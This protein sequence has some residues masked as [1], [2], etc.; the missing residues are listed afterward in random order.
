MRA[1]S[2]ITT[3]LGIVVLATMFVS[4]AS[5]ECGPQQGAK[6]QKQS[7]DGVS[8]PAS[9]L[10]VNFP[11]FNEPIVGMWHVVFT[12]EGNKGSM[13]PPDGA[14]IDNAVAVWHNDGTEIMNSGRP[15]QDG[16]FCLGVW[17]PTG[18]YRYKLNHFALGNDTTNAPSGIGNPAG[19]THIQETVTLGLDGDHFTGTF[20]LD[21]TSPTGSIE[22]HIIGSIKATRITVNTP[23]SS[24]F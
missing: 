15:A 12:A 2:K 4:V 8:N 14:I 24:F 22:A 3:V 17:E 18:H 1:K 20:I 9:L 16:N 13:A 7:W 19:P 5:A 10:Q 6:F 23:L 21:A 11:F